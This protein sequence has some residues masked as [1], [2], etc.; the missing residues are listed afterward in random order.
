MAAPLFDLPIDDFIIGRR[1]HTFPTYHLYEATHAGTG[2]PLVFKLL[3]SQNQE[4]MA[5]EEA[6][7]GLIK[8]WRYLLS[9]SDFL[10]VGGRLGYFLARADN[11]LRADVVIEGRREQ[12]LI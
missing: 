11:D 9:G 2:E 12:I 5:A 3:L 4:V 10:P 8:G 1:L 7:H 6:F